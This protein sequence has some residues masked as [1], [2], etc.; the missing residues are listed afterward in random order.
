MVDEGNVERH[1]DGRGQ[2]RRVLGAVGEAV[3]AVEQRIRRIDEAAV[4]VQGEAA[5]RRPGLQDRMQ[6]QA[7]RVDVVGQQ[8]GC[9][10]HGQDLLLHGLVAVGR[11]GGCRRIVGGRAQGHAV[12][13]GPD[14]QPVRIIDR[15]ALAGPVRRGEPAIAVAVEQRVAE[16]DVAGEGQFQRA[17]N[18]RGA[19]G[20]DESLVGLHAP[21]E[22][23]G[24]GGIQ[25]HQRRG[26][27]EPQAERHGSGIVEQGGH[28][29]RAGIGD[30]AAGGRHRRAGLR[31]AGEGLGDGC[32]QPAGQ[33][34]EVGTHQVVAAVGAGGARRCPHVHVDRLR[35]DHRVEGRVLSKG[36]H[37]LPDALQVF[38]HAGRRWDGVDEQIGGGG[39]GLAERGTQ[40]GRIE[41][42]GGFPLCLRHVRGDVTDRVGFIVQPDDRRRGRPLR[43]GQAG[44]LGEQAVL[45]GAG[46]PAIVPVAADRAQP[47]AQQAGAVRRRGQAGRGVEDDVDALVHAVETEQR[48]RGLHDQRRIATLRPGPQQHGVALA[49]NE[50]GQLDGGGEGWHGRVSQGHAAPVPTSHP[51]PTGIGIRVAP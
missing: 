45:V 31:I 9:R 3:G 35:R 11:G 32:R 25:G 1:R 19:A 49:A 5:M 47:L 7:R 38:R 48:L 4:R 36:L 33:L 22:A 42:D 24:G 17:A 39:R 20:R 44:H 12:G 46:G 10:R 2:I 43:C 34:P 13:G 30:V 29:L 50:D 28:H 15:V 40:G 23:G 14:G 37:A 18:Q 27:V 51:Q 21:A 8:T 41:P 26:M 6:R 16:M